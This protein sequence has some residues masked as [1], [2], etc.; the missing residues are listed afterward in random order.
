MGFVT[1]EKLGT[2]GSLGNQMFQLA[3]TI[4]MG[5]LYTLPVKIP[6]RSGYFEETYG[7]FVDYIDTG[8]DLKLDYLAPE[9]KT[10]FKYGENWTLS[11]FGFPISLEGYF[12]SEFYFSSSKELIKQK[13]TAFKPEIQS[14]ITSIS[15]QLP[16][17]KPLTAIH[18]RRGDYVNKQ[19]YHT[20]LPP[21]YYEAAK[22]E[23]GDNQS[24]DGSSGG[25][26]YVVFSDDL[27]WCRANFSDDHFFVE[28]GN[29]FVD[30]GVMIACDNFIIANSSFSWW[31]AWLAWNENKK[32]VAPKQWFGPKNRHLSTKDL[33]PSSWLQI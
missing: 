32:I 12:Q 8:L 22:K 31:G 27:P 30:L 11:P 17:N 14:Q 33:I 29:P 10:L 24:W 21:S 5:Q 9:D 15:T 20:L 2:F 26:N 6:K 4:T 19:D 3:A 7:R 18:V 13:F 23:I 1:F 28:S 25:Q 16:Y